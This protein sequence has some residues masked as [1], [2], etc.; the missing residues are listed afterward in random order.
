M[1]KYWFLFICTL[2]LGCAVTK[3]NH[4]NIETGENNAQIVRFTK[5]APIVKHYFTHTTGVQYESGSGK[6]YIIKSLEKEWWIT[7]NPDDVIDVPKLEDTGI[8]GNARAQTR[9]INTGTREVEIDSFI[10]EG[11]EHWR[12]IISADKVASLPDLEKLEIHIDADYMDISFLK[13]IAHIK[14]LIIYVENPHWSGNFEA[15]QYMIY[16]ESLK[17]I[18]I[19]KVD[20][21][22]SL[23]ISPIGNLVNLKR[24]YVQSRFA[25]M[26]IDPIA[27]LANLES[28]ELGLGGIDLKT[29]AFANLSKL[30]F[31]KISNAKELHL[32]SIGNLPKL[33]RLAISASD[34]IGN[35]SSLQN[36]ELEKL[37]IDGPW[38]TRD[39]QLDIDWLSNLPSLNELHIY[40]FHIDDLKPLLKLPSIENIYISN[41][42]DPNVFMPLL[43]SKTIR[44]IYIPYNLYH[45]NFPHELFEERGIWARTSD[46]IK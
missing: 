2:F 26:N 15:L 5:N 21:Q 10:F 42:T 7:D 13:S 32:A 25:Q 40:S 17:I 12:L 38:D 31:L 30:E 6:Y 8:R 14:D 45:S 11:V 36:P 23:D 33:K 39:K 28:L 29:D 24:L 27:N 43:E 19:H 1:I 16:L 44:S 3:T 22:N 46:D 18:C 20:S 9:V 37:V 35:N 4:N 41:I 34:F